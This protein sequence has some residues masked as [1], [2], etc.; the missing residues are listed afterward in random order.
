MDYAQQVAGEAMKPAKTTSFLLPIP[1]STSHPHSITYQLATDDGHRALWVVFALMLISS[2]IFAGLSWNIP[3]SRRLY[4]VITSMI[5]ITAALSYFAMA[6][7]DGIS[8]HCVVDSA[9][10]H[11]PGTDAMHE[12][13]RQV[14]WARYVDWSLTT[15]L[16][17][18]D[19]C[20]LSGMD[21]A[22]TL[23]A[24]LADVVMVLTGMFAA[25]GTTGTAQ[26]WGWYAIACVA[27]A[28]IIWH[29]ALHGSRM[30]TAKGSKVVKLFS[31]LGAFTL[32]LWT[33]YPIVWAIADGSRRTSVDTEIMLYA[34]LDI[35][36]KPVFGLWLL[37]SH[38]NVPETNIELGGYWSNGLSSEG[39]IRIGDEN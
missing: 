15:P 17:L 20:L 29:V 32:I 12:V 14:Y 22:H 26:K 19:L 16:L 2:G 10:H 7:G 31:S 38:R 27:Y 34:V 23:M 8:L 39:H 21:G 28:F 25:F 3:V 4:H 11:K 37:L 33:A 13:C 6:T 9:A 36:A 24:I 5:V 35:L 1:T 30:V 18:L